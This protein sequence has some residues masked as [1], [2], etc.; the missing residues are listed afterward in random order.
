M[1]DVP[2][3]L[4][5][6][7]R[8]P[9]ADG[10]ILLDRADGIATIR[11]NHPEKHNA[12]SVEMWEGFGFALKDAAAD[13][14]VRVLVLTGEGGKAFVSGG[15]ISQFE[16]THSSP[17][18]RAEMERRAGAWRGLLANFPRPTLAAIRGYCI[19]GG[20][21]LALG[22]HIRLAT[23]NS[24]FGIP[25]AKLSIA[26]PFDGLRVL[27]QLVGP[28]WARLLMFSAMRIDSAEAQRI[29]LVNRVV[30]DDA[31]DAA[32]QELAAGIAANAPLSVASS[33]I[34]IRELLREPADRDMAA[35][36]EAA[37]ACTASTDAV[38]GRRA[39]M[40]KRPP[41]FTGR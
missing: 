3:A 28:S 30:D 25:A 35:V 13:P 41:R 9:Y 40:E 12:M 14:D 32:V 24:Q 19:G 4:D 27:T 33:R 36:S 11:F 16:A 22:A 21:A 8:V 29:G 18:A 10:R 34:A 15:D 26:Y 39:F 20:L 38:E 37:R 7:S 2:D 1:R 6:A 5:T 23:R 17:E 31:L